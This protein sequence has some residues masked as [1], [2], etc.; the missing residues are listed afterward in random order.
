M[1]GPRC[2]SAPRGVVE[3]GARGA[4]AADDARVRVTEKSEGVAE[5]D[6]STSE[7]AFSWPEVNI[8]GVCSTDST[9]SN[10]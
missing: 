4:H 5:S 2:V 3:Q 10:R 6:S 1:T 7:S 9:R 8:V